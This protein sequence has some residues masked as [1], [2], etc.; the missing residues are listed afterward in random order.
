MRRYRRDTMLLVEWTDIMEDPAW[1]DHEKAGEEKP[2][3]CSTLGFYLNHDKHVVRLSST[4]AKDQ[5]NVVV[6]PLGCIKKVRKV[7]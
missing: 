4:I 5:R 7:T 2:E 1:M 3:S 6:I